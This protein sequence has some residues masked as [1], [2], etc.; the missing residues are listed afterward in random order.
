MDEDRFE[1]LKSLKE[2]GKEISELALTF[3]TSE[4]CLGMP[5]RVALIPNGFEVGV[6]ELTLRPY[7]QATLK[8]WLFDRCKEQLRELLLG[9]YEVVPEPLLAVFDYQELEALMCGSYYEGGNAE[10][11]V[12]E[13]DDRKMASRRDPDLGDSIL[14]ASVI[15]AEVQ[16]VIDAEVTPLIEATLVE[17]EDQV[18]PQVEEASTTP[19]L[20][21]HLVE[22]QEFIVEGE[23]FDAEEKKRRIKNGQCITCGIQTHKVSK[24]FNKQFPISSEYVLSGRCLLCNPI[25]SGA[26]TTPQSIDNSTSSAQ[27]REK[28]GLCTKCGLVKTHKRDS[29]GTGMSKITRV[30]QV[31]KGICL[32]CYTLDEAKMILREDSEG[33]VS[34]SGGNHNNRHSGRANNSNTRDESSGGETLS[35]AAPPP[36]P[37]LETEIEEVSRPSSRR[38][39][40]GQ[41]LRPYC[42]ESLAVGEPDF[43]VT[44][45]MEEQ[46]QNASLEEES[47]VEGDTQHG[48]SASSNSAADKIFSRDKMDVQMTSS[49]DSDT[50]SEQPRPLSEVLKNWFESNPDHSIKFVPGTTILPNAKT[51]LT[52]TKPSEIP[53]A[54]TLETY[55][56]KKDIA[57]YSPAGTM[58]TLPS[59]SD[60]S[61]NDESMNEFEETRTQ[62]IA[63][64]EDLYSSAPIQLSSKYVQRIMTGTRLGGGYYGQVYLGVDSLVGNFAIK[65][66]NPLVFEQALT[67]RLYSI[68]QS[69]KN[70]VKVSR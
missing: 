59:S 69:F 32:S 67:N 15:N 33:S 8:Y 50:K 29:L 25:P 66:I 16:P 70:E 39:R 2:M 54:L 49:D 52:L 58:T 27:Y 46:T 64:V 30:G 40:H 22:S 12:V 4:E 18:A 44:A 23:E 6:D 11:E 9:F 37:D 10:E 26:E 41:D 1:F 5:K 21:A 62:L 31:Y 24:L 14:D 56:R 61:E 43:D 57:G 60:A 34:Q 19:I 48:N 68:Q 47:T 45:E 42:I 36:P 63:K 13:E 35:L 7:I 53:S 55:F 51:E 3:T 38:L 65:I 28:K 20:E 17:D